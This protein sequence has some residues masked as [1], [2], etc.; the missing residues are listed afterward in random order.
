MQEHNFDEILD[1]LCSGIM[2][3]GERQSVRDE[4]Y[5]HLMCRYET[6]LAVGMD[7]EKAAEKAVESLG[8]KNTLKF[9]LQKVHWY[10]PALTLKK[11][12]SF[13]TFALISPIVGS[14]LGAAFFDI[15]ALSVVAVISIPLM[16]CAVF[17]FRTVKKSGLTPWLFI[18]SLVL[19]GLTYAIY[20]IIPE[21]ELWEKIT[22]VANQLAFMCAVSFIF[23]LKSLLKP[24]GDTSDATAAGCS[25]VPLVF[26]SMFLI[27]PLI[28]ESSRFVAYFTIIPAVLLVWFFISQM[29]KI[30]EFLFEHDHE[31]KIDLSWKKSILIFT[32]SFALIIT[33]VCVVDYS[34]STKEITAKPY[35]VNDADISQAEYERICANLVS[36][37]I[38][39]A[40]VELMPKSE[41]LNYK[42]SIHL[43]EH[44][45]SARKY[46]EQN[47]GLSSSFS[48]KPGDFDV[49]FWR[50]ISS[51][52]NRVNM[53]NY[54]VG[55][56][57]GKVR[58]IKVFV[59]PQNAVNWYYDSVVLDD[60]GMYD[61]GIYPLS[62][63]EVK[64]YGRDFLLALKI[65]EKGE[66]LFGESEITD[67]GTGVG[68]IESFK[69]KADPGTV[70]IFATTRY[71][72]DM[73]ASRA[74]LNFTYYH[75]KGPVTFPVRNVEQSISY[76]NRENI[77]G[78]SKD[79]N[80]SSYHTWVMPGNEYSYSD[81]IIKEKYTDKYE[82]LFSTINN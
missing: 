2:S 63:D 24:F 82:G 76:D 70:V 47:D 19:M 13:L 15:N 79:N 81:E 7:E 60:G 73:N 31:Y 41:I 77:F 49:F 32:L 78:Y 38:P 61:H 48:F 28:E 44:T 37:G 34:V 54:A 43:S 67:Y 64:E 53:E 5:D 26:I 58:F 33:S 3:K 16:I 46:M 11:A 36:Y 62:S 75:Q 74:N 52:Y 25:F 50:N 57:N 39:E 18:F 6:N 42:E 29:R 4:L 66:I 14:V 59:I 21:T 9:K 71:I 55:L 45:E 65:N 40:Y 69:F 51:T 1:F 10:Y 30:S 56:G 80:I 20:P 72:A 23:D 27:V 12:L 22:Q 17:P 8:D 68:Y 35:S